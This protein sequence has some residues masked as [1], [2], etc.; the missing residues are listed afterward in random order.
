MIARGYLSYDN[1]QVAFDPEFHTTPDQPTPGVPTGHVTARALNSAMRLMNAYSARQG[2]EHQKLLLVHEWIP[3]MVRHPNRLL[4][5]LPYVQPALIM[6]GIGSP[7]DKLQRYLSLLG[8]A[9]MGRVL[10][11]IKLFLSSRY[12]VPAA[13]DTPMLSWEQL[14]GAAPVQDQHGTPTFIGP[15]PRIIVLS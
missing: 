14:F 5:R 11:G 10:P 13:V 2:L 1:V 9:P 8:R 12:S 15:L 4:Q 3:G 7:N 6:D